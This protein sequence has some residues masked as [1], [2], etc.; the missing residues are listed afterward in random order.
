MQKNPFLLFFGSINFNFFDENLLKFF[1]THFKSIMQIFNFLCKIL[2]QKIEK[3]LFT[4]FKISQNFSILLLKYFR[5][6]LTLTEWNHS[7][8]ILDD[9]DTYPHLSQWY[10]NIARR[11]HPILLIKLEGISMAIN[12]DMISFLPLVP[13]ETCLFNFRNCVRDSS[14]K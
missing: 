8:N 12:L 6:S 14:L 5:I 1:L 13:S 7:S 4:Q 11:L 3:T 9:D 2:L 10:L